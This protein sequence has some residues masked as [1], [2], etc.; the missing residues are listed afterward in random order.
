MQVQKFSVLVSQHLYLYVSCSTDQ[1]FDQ[2]GPVA[3][4]ALGMRPGLAYGIFKFLLAVYFTHTNATTAGRCL[5]QQRKTHGGYSFQFG[6]RGAFEADGG[7][8]GHIVG[9]SYFP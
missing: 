5:Y 1:V 3:K 4:L 8:N 2:Q 7:H 9:E 6:L